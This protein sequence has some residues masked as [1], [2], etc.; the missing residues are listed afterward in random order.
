MPPWYEKRHKVELYLA[1]GDA[2]LA[3]DLQALVCEV[4]IRGIVAGD[5]SVEERVA[6]WIALRVD[7]F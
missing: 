1:A 3:G 5:K 2:V 6:V 4:W 7:D